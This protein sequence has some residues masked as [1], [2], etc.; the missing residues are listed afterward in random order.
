MKNQYTQWAEKNLPDQYR[1]FVAIAC[2]MMERNGIET[3]PQSVQQ[4]L[5]AQGRD[6]ESIIERHKRYGSSKRTPQQDQ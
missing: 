6:R 2:E 1:P 4:R 3:T 5:A